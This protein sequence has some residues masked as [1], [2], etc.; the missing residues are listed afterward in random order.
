MIPRC[1]TAPHLFSSVLGQTWLGIALS[2]LRTMFKFGLQFFFFAFFLFFVENSTTIGITIA[3]TIDLQV[4]DRLRSR[5]LLRCVLLLVWWLVYQALELA[6][7]LIIVSIFGWVDIELL[8]RYFLSLHAFFRLLIFN[9]KYLIINIIKKLLTIN[10]KNKQINETCCVA[11]SPRK[12]NG[13]RLSCLINW[14]RSY[15]AVWH[16]AWW[17]CLRYWQ[18][19]A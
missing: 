14:Q 5:I 7:A 1:R 18:L 16:N 6:N 10:L 9:Y 3:A 2:R 19:S 13:K 11:R 8:G 17:Q 12:S 4:D 15:G